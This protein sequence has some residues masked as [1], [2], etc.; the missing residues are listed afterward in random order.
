M[1]MARD[2][3]VEAYLREAASWDEDRA[4]R[5]RSSERRAWGLAGIATLLAGLAI[6]AVVLLTP[7]KTVQPF[8]VRVDN[9]TGVVD[10]VPVYTGTTEA[11]PVMT[12]YLL[13]SYVTARE[14]YVAPLAESDYDLVG[15]FNSA[16][17]NQVWA[18]AWDRSNPESPLLRYRDGTTVRAQVQA[19][20]FLTRS[21]GV[22]DVAQ[23]RF[24]RALRAGGTGVEQVS[25]WIAT[26]QYAYGAPSKDER[27]RS[28]NP[29]GF[30]ILDYR[31][32]AEIVA[33]SEKGSPATGMA[34]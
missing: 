2:A 34:P 27:L 11:A 28:L 14:R 18:A 10:V 24:M 33:E 3:S 21:T 13:N 16:S 32:D 12:R 23:V 8:V 6:V 29:M 1:R 7:L 22:N 17:V 25:H 31:R 20:S 19:V 30:K 26:I 9:S 15:A 5:M 4:R